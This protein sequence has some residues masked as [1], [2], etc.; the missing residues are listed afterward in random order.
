MCHSV[1]KEYS[2]YLDP[3]YTWRRCKGGKEGEEREDG[4]KPY[5]VLSI[6]TLNDAFSYIV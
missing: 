1:W 3:Y 4:Q 6:L 5:F 2:S